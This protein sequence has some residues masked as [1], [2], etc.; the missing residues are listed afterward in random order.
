LLFATLSGN[1]VLERDAIKKDTKEE[2]DLD[3]LASDGDDADDERDDDDDSSSLGSFTAAKADIKLMN[4]VRAIVVLALLTVACIASDT[5]VVVTTMAEQSNFNQAYRQAAN[6][7]GDGFLASV[8][9]IATVSNNLAVEL[10]LADGF[11]GWPFVTF[12]NFQGR[13]AGTVAQTSAASIA[14]AP[15]VTSEQR[16]DWETY[17]ATDF[18]P[19]STAAGD[20]VGGD[21]QNVKYY[22][23]NRKADE[24]IY[25][26]TSSGRAETEPDRDTSIPIWQMSP[27]YSNAS[28]LVGKLFQLS[29]NP[30]RQQSIES[31][32]IGR[33]T[34][35][36]DFLIDNTNGTDYAV[37]ATPHSAFFSPLFDKVSTIL[38]G[39]GLAVAPSANASVVGAIVIDVPWTRMLPTLEEADGNSQPLIAVVQSSCGGSGAVN[40]YSFQMASTRGILFLGNGDEHNPKVNGYS[41][42]VRSFNSSSLPSAQN[43]FGSCSFTI[44]IYPSQE[45]KEVYFTTRPD[46]FR[47]IVLV[48]FV[49]V[50]CV[51]IFYDHIVQVSQ[52]RVVDAAVRSDAIVRS[53]F[54]AAVRDKLYEQSK[55]KQEAA[56]AASKG[57]ALVTAK[58]RLL[59]FVDDDGFDESPH[60]DPNM[61]DEPIADLFS[62]A[63]VLFAD[64]SGFTAWSSERDPSQVRS[65][66]RSSFS[67]T[68]RAHVQYH[69]AIRSS[70]AFFLFKPQVFTL[71]ENV[72]R[73]MDKLAKKYRVFKVETVGDCYVAAT[74]SLCFRL[75]LFFFVLECLSLV[76]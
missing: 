55:L 19:F 36:T 73:E 60:T 75:L 33:S 41:P 35:M 8:V 34:V 62:Q 3:S 20:V 13:T 32:K 71:L 31:M 5:V 7:I 49:S 64:I 56:K 58:R 43:A 28:S 69:F 10:T 12:G 47:V 76:P 16:N 66:T 59:N 50:I 9:E 72:Y 21:Q 51:F 2:D 37:Y 18:S 11:K 30:V 46:I 48:V 25:H 14:F 70:L 26:F 23:V 63:T 53:M 4:V 68:H 40:T 15:L 54:P 45:F 27:S 57:F 17:A 1:M 39:D 67:R 22:R 24:G 42:V 38:S 61:L 29:S 74:V 52:N 44:F 65:S 6:D